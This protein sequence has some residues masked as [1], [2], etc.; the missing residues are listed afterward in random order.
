[1][2]PK[3]DFSVK[4][5]TEAEGAGAPLIA[6]FA[7]SGIARAERNAERLATPYFLDAVH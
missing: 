4:V 1:M 3:S 2:A 7:M 6:L 5:T